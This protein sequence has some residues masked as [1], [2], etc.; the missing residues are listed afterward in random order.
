MSP[1]QCRGGKLTYPSDIY[2][3]GVLIF[4]IFTG[5]VP[6]RGA[7]P[8]ATLLMHIEEPLSLE[9]PAVERLPKSL[10]AIVKKALNKQPAARFQTAGSVA[11]ALRQARTGTQP[12]AVRSAGARLTRPHPTL[13]HGRRA[14]SAVRRRASRHPSTSC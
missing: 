10:L 8:L 9:G 6:F 1:E 13:H 2:A 5:T 3:L 11:E 4:E 12:P 14:R 7:T